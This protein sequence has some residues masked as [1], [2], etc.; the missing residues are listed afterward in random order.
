M[1]D[2]TCI[3]SLRVREI[4]NW[5]IGFTVS[6]EGEQW[7]VTIWG[8]EAP[9]ELEE[10]TQTLIRAGKAALPEPVQVLLEGRKKDDV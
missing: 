6:P 1:P 10:L 4:E 5:D 3:G 9:G 8:V 2:D 7:V